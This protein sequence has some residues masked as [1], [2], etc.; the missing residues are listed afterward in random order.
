MDDAT[1]RQVAEA[2]IDDTPGAAAVADRI[3]ASKPGQGSE[4]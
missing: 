2:H 4:S 1:R 3:K